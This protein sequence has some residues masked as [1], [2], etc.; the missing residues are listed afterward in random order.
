[1]FYGPFFFLPNSDLEN[2][3]FSNF[4]DDLTCSILKK[5]CM[6]LKV[7]CEKLF[8]FFIQENGRFFNPCEKVL[9][10]C[11]SCPPNNIC[12]ERLMGKL[13]K[14]MRDAPT[15]DIFTVESSVIFNDNRTSE[16]LKMKAANEKSKIIK[17]TIQET[18]QIKRKNKEDKARLLQQQ[19][20]LIK[21]RQDSVKKAKERKQRIVDEAVEFIQDDGLWKECD[22]DAEVGKLKNK[23]EKMKVVK[24]QINM[25][26]NVFSLERKSRELTK[27]SSKGKP[28]S[29]DSLIENLKS[30]ICLCKEEEEG[31]KSSSPDPRSL[32]H[33]YILHTWTTDDMQNIEWN[34]QIVAFKDGIFKVKIFGTPISNLCTPN[35][36]T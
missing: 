12:V 13:D 3:L 8:E 28:L 16:W 21:D 4:Y 10:D 33:K 17:E 35:C 6:C 11:K 19:L 20:R 30:I 36:S 31:R 22:V 15:C 1:M 23:T 32:V 7:K 27:F 25:Y 5:F 2:V 26:K 34:G 29:L 18:R 14:K 24:K 9:N